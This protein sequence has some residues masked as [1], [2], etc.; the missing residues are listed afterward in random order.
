M[1]VEKSTNVSVCKYLI[2]NMLFRPG[3]TQVYIQCTTYDIQ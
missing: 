3:P 1:G 2:S